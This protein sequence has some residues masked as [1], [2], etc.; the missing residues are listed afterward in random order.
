MAIVPTIAGFAVGGGLASLRLRSTDYG[1]YQVALWG[2]AL[3]LPFIAMFLFVSGTQ[4]V[5]LLFAA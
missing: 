1:L 2:V 4:A 5:P 3:G